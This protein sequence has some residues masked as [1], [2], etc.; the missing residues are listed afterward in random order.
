MAYKPTMYEK[1]TIILTNEAE[2]FYSVYT[3]TSALKR[4][5]AEYAKKHPELC[6]LTAS[7]PE[8]SVTY[9]VAKDRLKIRLAEPF[10]AERRQAMSERAKN[11][12]R[13]KNNGESV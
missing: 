11:M 12:N 9:K 1:E 7:T 8:G 3:Y 4:Q 13:G 2:D 6:E 5:L 10:S